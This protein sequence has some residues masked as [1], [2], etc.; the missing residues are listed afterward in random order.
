MRYNNMQQCITILKD[1]EENQSDLVIKSDAMVMNENASV[2]IPSLSPAD[3]PM[4]QWAHHQMANKL[5]IPTGY[6]NRMLE[7]DRPLLSSNV[8]RWL[9]E[10]NNL[11]VR[12]ESGTARAILS[13][14]YKIVQNRLVLL[15]VYN[16]LMDMQR[17]F[18]TRS[19]SESDTTFY[20]KF[21]GEEAYDMGNGDLH[22]GGVVI[23]NSEVGAS[24][25]RV[26]YFVCRLSCGNDAIFSDDGISRVHLGRKLETGLIDY[27]SDTIEADNVAMMKA[28]RDIVQ[29]AFDP[30]GIQ[31]IYDRVNLSKD[32]PIKE[33]GQ[34]IR[35]I[36]A[37]HRLS[38][39]LTDRLLISLQGVT[40]FDIAQTVTLNAQHIKDE[41]RRIEMEELGGALLV[42]PKEK[43][44]E[45][46]K[47]KEI[48]QKEQSF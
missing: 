20:A 11:L 30:A 42:M 12:T 47:P 39:E 48:A 10:A 46:Y 5:D 24:R 27:A 1:R 28:I 4:T 22:R 16:T 8:N 3:I 31:S 21:V 38:D 29:T 15:T 41:D 40:Q 35:Q 32:N 43:F 23:R 7:A 33:T 44:N 13:S 45:Q 14:K 17:P 6:Y 36:Q 34:V 18:L 25:L 37:Q 2:R 19:L 26:D 9:R